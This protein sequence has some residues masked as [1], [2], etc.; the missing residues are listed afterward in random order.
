M[1]EDLS[2]TALLLDA[3]AALRVLRT[4]C[5]TIPLPLGVT[6]AEAIIADIETYLRTHGQMP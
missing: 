6:R 2:A 4:M 3:L 1:A 5:E